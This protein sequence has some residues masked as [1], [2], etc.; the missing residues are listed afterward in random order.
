MENFEI[1]RS[2]RK[3]VSIEI[4]RDMRVIVRAPARMRQKDIEKFIEE[5]MPWIEKHLEL[6]RQRRATEAEI[7]PIEP[8]TAAQIEEL[9]ARALDTIPPRVAELAE[10]VGVTYG[11]ITI[12]NQVSRW[13]SCS[14]KGNLNFNCLLML[15]PERVVDYVIIHEL[16]HRRH[17]NHSSDFWAMVEKYCPDLK[18]S[19]A[20]LRDMGGAMIARL[21]ATD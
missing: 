2:G 15:C 10:I 16:C 14:A 6:M 11:R 20:W 13:G 9:A 12:R 5:K 21:R 7:G 17:M 8:F 19:K 4:K 18:E 3:T 1:I